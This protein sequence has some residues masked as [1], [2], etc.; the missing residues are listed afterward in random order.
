M[1][2][3]I[4]FLMVMLQPPGKS[5]YSAVPVEDNIIC[6]TEYTP[7]CRRE[8]KEEGHERYKVI[9]QVIAEVSGGQSD[10]ALKILTIVYHES[11][12]RRDV[13]S[14]KGKFARGDLGRS[15]GLGQRNLG[16]SRTRRGLS[17]YD[18]VGVNIEATRRSIMTIGD[19][20]LRI[21]G[22]RSFRCQLAIYGGLH[23]KSR[24]K[25]VMDRVAV[26]G[27]LKQIYDRM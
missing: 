11:G 20:L 1:K 15:C 26:Y 6:N 27:K 21:K 24:F 16:L 17:C 7:G 2:E 3:L 12:F 25:G 18:L 4:L 14:G 9:A 19:Y 8:T 5:S 10:L 23:S 22:C 13:H